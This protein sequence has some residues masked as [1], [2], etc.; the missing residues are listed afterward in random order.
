MASDHTTADCRTEE[1]RRGAPTAWL[2]AAFGLLVAFWLVA[3]NAGWFMDAPFAYLGRD[4]Y[5]DNLVQSLGRFLSPAESGLAVV[6][7]LILGPALAFTALSLARW[8]TADPLK[9]LAERIG[10]S[11]RNV[12]LLL[13]F[14]AACGALFVSEGLL[15]HAELIDD[16]RAYAFQARLFAHGLASLPSPP[17]ALRN[18][19][20]LLQPVWASKY[21]P[22]HSL[23]LALGVLLGSERIVPPL[24]AFCLVL[25][26]WYW[27]KTVFGPRQALLAA[28]ICSLSPFVW[29]VHGTLM[30]TTTSCVAFAAFLAAMAAAEQGHEVAPA[31]AG[32]AIGVA[33]ATRPY[34]AL[35]LSLPFACL[36]LWEAVARGPRER[37]RCGLVVLG[38]CSSGWLLLWNNHVLL[39]SVWK[40]TW[41]AGDAAFRLGFYIHPFPGMPYVHTPAAAIGNLTAVVVRLEQWLFAWPGAMLLVACGALRPNPGRWDRLLRAS[42]LSYV[43]L[44]SLIF[45]SGVWDTG[46]VYY[47]ACLPLLI[48]L[49]T[50]GAHWLRSIAPPFGQRVVAWT[51]VG[52]S[53]MAWVSIAPLHAASLL[54][55]GQELRKPWETI[56]SAG[57]GDA[58]VVVPPPYLRRAPGWAYGYPYKIRTG[59]HTFAHL[60]EPFDRAEFDEAERQVGRRPT[61]VLS[62]D[63]ELFA[64]KGVRAYAVSPFDP[65]AYFGGTNR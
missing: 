26:T 1:G 12:A 38:F 45:G 5:T 60:L 25:C 39:G 49:F 35:A 51:V 27:V 21:P 46:P 52:G 65:D 36:L 34:E 61:Y 22:A 43:L 42:L 15:S 28:V 50:R 14:I 37:L 41:L 59:D 33:F 58:N 17:A 3:S 9:T 11:E 19:M 30:A 10:N 48:A 55:F 63:R 57:I 32:V 6:S 24:L 40:F 18:P 62:V 53:V 44:Y 54:V 4:L 64:N 2:V 56:A 13:A 23:L 7:A 31:L 16:E 8:R 47:Y 29:A 20:L